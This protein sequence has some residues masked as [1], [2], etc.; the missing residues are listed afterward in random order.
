MSEQKKPTTGESTGGS[1]GAGRLSRALGASDPRLHRNADADLSTDTLGG[2][3][4]RDQEGRI[5]PKFRESSALYVDEE[6]FIELNTDESMEQS[7]GSRT[8]L[9]NTFARMVAVL[10]GNRKRAQAPAR[11]VLD[12]ITND[13]PHELAGRT[14]REVLVRAASDPS[15]AN[16]RIQV[17]YAGTL[18]GTR[19][20]I[21]FIKAGDCPVDVTLSDDSTNERVDI[22]IAS[23]NTGTGTVIVVADGPTISQPI[24]ATDITIP[25]TGLHVL[26]TDA[27]HDLIFKPGSNIT[28]DRTLTITTGDSDRTL[29]LSGNLTVSDTSTFSANQQIRTITFVIDGGG[30]TITTGVKGFLEIPFACTI[31]RATLL[32]D[33][34]GSIVVD[35][36]KDTYANYPPTVADTITA[37][38]K[39]TISAATKAQDATLTGWT[40]AIAAG[41]ILGFNV[42]SITT[43]QRVT[44]SLRVTVT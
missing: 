35:I 38:A 33:Q 22:T 6:G 29:T 30:A 9:R 11:L 28:A 23:T 32:A 7:P 43:C 21:N 16:A 39:P 37:S 36:W 14:L 19:R 17:Q 26:D 3:L 1:Y 5:I 8:A 41:D 10:T 44:L 40:T 34:S 42:D 31:T 15:D 20:A 4:T 27:S 24:I 12:D 2:G 18:Y 25:N 13:R